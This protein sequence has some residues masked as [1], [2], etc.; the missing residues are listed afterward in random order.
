VNLEK[1]TVVVKG[2]VPY[3]VVHE[4]IKKTGKEVGCVVGGF[5]CFAELVI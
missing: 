5:L 4:K 1:Q 3:D 2:D